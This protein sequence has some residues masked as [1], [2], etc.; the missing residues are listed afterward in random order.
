MG[1][2]GEGPGMTRDGFD[3]QMARLFGLR[4]A[5]VDTE[6]HWEALQDIPLVVLT[7]AITRAQKTRSDFPTPIELREDADVMA[8]VVIAPTE[9]RSV[10]LAQPFTIT[11]PNVGTVVSVTREWK[12]YCEI[13][14][15]NGW[16][17]FWCG[18]DGPG[19][20][21]WYGRGS[22]ERRGAHGSH[23]WVK[24]CLCFESN[25]ALVRQRERTQKYAEQKSQKRVA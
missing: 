6:T 20:K 9:D 24:R 3:K 7:A 23:E 10:E 15:D 5:P 11:V 4:F 18:D 13:C 1:R 25:P 14:S 2:T 22:C 17:A 8:H 12:Y 21:P 19:L 16:A